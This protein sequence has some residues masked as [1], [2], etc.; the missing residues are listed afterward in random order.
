ME[1]STM[2]AHG[3]GDISGAQ[4]MD[5]PEIDHL[6]DFAAD[7]HKATSAPS[8]VEDSAMNFGHVKPCAEVQRPRGARSSSALT[9]GSSNK[10]RPT[11]A[12]TAGA[13]AIVPRGRLHHYRP[14]RAPIR[15]L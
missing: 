13:A 4:D 6:Q 5:I 1:C 11:R 2:V 7:E 15:E 14:R 10:G 12:W 9:A 3:H 8:Q